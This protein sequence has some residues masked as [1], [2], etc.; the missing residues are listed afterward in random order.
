MLFR[1]FEDI[2]NVLCSLDVIL[3]S[4]VFSADVRNS[5]INRVEVILSSG[6]VVINVVVLLIWVCFVAMSL[7]NLKKNLFLYSLVMILWVKK[8]VL[9]ISSRVEEM[10]N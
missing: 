2:V 6:G 8:H 1:I 4:P 10:I 9:I 3:G 7:S 5:L